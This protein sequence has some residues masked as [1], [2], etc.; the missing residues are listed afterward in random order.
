MVLALGILVAGALVWVLVASLNHNPGPAANASDSSPMQTDASGSTPG[1]SKAS[2][3]PSP[4]G[5][6]SAKPPASG[7]TDPGTASETPK[8]PATPE[9]PNGSGTTASTPPSVAPVTKFE[10]AKPSN[11]P[12]GKTTGCTYVLKRLDG[13]QTDI[14]A[15]GVDGMRNWLDAIDDL[16]GDPSMVEHSPGFD[17]VKRTWSTALAAAEENG[18]ADGGPAFKDGTVAMQELVDGIHCK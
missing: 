12:T 3:T 7:T 14:N 8:I 4:S 15:S 5:S 17:A 6:K 1:A 2:A 10:D 18:N 9:T 11:W 16:Q 13:I